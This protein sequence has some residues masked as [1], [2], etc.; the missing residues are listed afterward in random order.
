MRTAGVAAATMAAAVVSLVWLV[1]GSPMPDAG[2]WAEAGVPQASLLAGGD[3][4]PILDT[5]HR[6]EARDVEL[7]LGMAYEW[8]TTVDRDFCAAVSHYRRAG[9]LGAA[10]GFVF[11]SLLTGP[12][13]G[14]RDANCL[15]CVL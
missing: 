1:D 15:R 6:R 9:E 7:R 8:G 13:G 11:A 4:L 2:A 14:E 10:F 3:T 12:S 5:E